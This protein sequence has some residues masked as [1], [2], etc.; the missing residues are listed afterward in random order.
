MKTAAVDQDKLRAIIG[1]AVAEADASDPAR[2]KARIAELERA[3]SKP[4]TPTAGGERSS[5]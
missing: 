2:L 5:P 3:A 1:D 4:A